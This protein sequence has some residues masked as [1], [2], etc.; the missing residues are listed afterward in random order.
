M[1]DSARFPVAQL[2]LIIDR[3]PL[4]VNAADELGNA[5][6]LRMIPIPLQGLFAV[7]LG[8]QNQIGR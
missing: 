8:I 4:A 2:K 5:Q 1:L 3:L 6:M 7:K